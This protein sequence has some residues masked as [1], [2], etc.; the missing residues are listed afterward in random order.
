[1]RWAQ[2]SSVSGGSRACS[3]AVRSGSRGA[4]SRR[5]ASRVRA[6]GSGAPRRTAGGVGRGA[7]GGA[8]PQPR[9]PGESGGF[10]TTTTRVEGGWEVSGSKVFPTSAPGATGAILLVDPAGPGGAR[11]SGE[12]GE[13]VLMLACRLADPA[14]SV[15]DSWWDPIGMR[16]TVSHLVRFDDAFVPDA[17]VIGGAGGPPPPGGGRGGLPPFPA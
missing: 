6:A 5:H 13:G 11:H 4:A 10:G 17:D 1:M 12:S 7:G 8:G 14:V 9:R 16:A 2:P 3:R 15:D